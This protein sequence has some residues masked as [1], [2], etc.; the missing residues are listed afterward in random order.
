M[1]DINI[2]E[3]GTRQN[4]LFNFR[5]LMTIQ[6]LWKLSL[7]NLNTIAVALYEEIKGQAAISFIEDAPVANQE[8]QLKLDIVKRV[9]E[10]KKAEK[11]AAKILADK[12]AKKQRLLEI[13]NQKQ[14]EA[15]TSM[16]VEELEK[17]LAEL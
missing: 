1:S 12:K 2:F 9:I 17:Q 7:Q 16:S 13:L 10:V 15:L 11:E 4:V 3:Q 14:D 8:L 5:G 6:D